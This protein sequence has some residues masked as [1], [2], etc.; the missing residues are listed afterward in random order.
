MQNSFLL[1][2][3]SF[4]RE[5]LSQI[6]CFS[7]SLVFLCASSAAFADAV[8]IVPAKKDKSNVPISRPFYSKGN[9]VKN[10]QQA[11][12]QWALINQVE[13]LQQEVQQLRGVVEEQAYRLEQFKKSSR[14]RYLDLDRRFSQL[15]TRAPGPK[16]TKKQDVRAAPVAKASI[17]EK[18]LYEKAKK[19]VRAKQFKEAISLFNRLLTDYPDGAFVSNAYYWLGEVNLALATPNY[20][21]AEIHFLKLLQRDAKHR[22]VPAA[23]FKLGKLY[24]MTG[25]SA[26][27]DKY[28]NRVIQQ[29]PQSGAASL[30]RKYLDAMGS[31]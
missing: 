14:D 18:T 4:C 22:K 19:K 26:L 17:K 28:L 29:H 11:S 10:K 23:L 8:L 13:R 20:Q 9:V 6:F 31:R 24:D 21:N 27:A 25:Q 2:P 12:A 5:R 16:M 15:G 1:V 3:I 7:L 30:S